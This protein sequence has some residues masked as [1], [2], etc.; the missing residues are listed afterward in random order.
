MSKDISELVKRYKE[1]HRSNKNIYFDAYEFEELADYFDS[2]NDIDEVKQVIE[3]GLKIHPKNSSLIIKKLKLIVYNY[4]YEKALKI[5]DESALEYDYDLNLLKIECYLVLGMEDEALFST[6]EILENEDGNLDEVFEDI[7]FVYFELSK[8]DEA[9]VFFKHSLEFNSE[10]LEVLNNLAYIYRQ[11]DSTNELIEI[12]N[13][14][15]DIDSYTYDSWVE[16]GK[17]YFSRQEYTKA[18]DALDFALTIKDDDVNVLKLKAECLP[19]LNRYEEAIQIYQK[20]VI[21][22]SYNPSVF[23][24]LIDLYISCEMYEKAHEVI[25][26]YEAS[27]GKSDD[28]I[29]KR[30]DIYIR[31][32]SIEKALEFVSSTENT[33]SK[34]FEMNMLM[35]EIYF[36]KKELK[37]AEYYF[38]IAISMSDK[39]SPLVYERLSTINII[40]KNYR[41]GLFYASRLLEAFPYV[42]AN[43]G[44]VALLYYQLELFE[45][46][47]ALIQYFTSS[48]FTSLSLFAFPSDTEP[49]TDKDGLLARFKV[50]R[51]KGTL[52]NILKHLD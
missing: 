17:L 27:F 25:D 26:S 24:P 44:R 31:A 43:I 8:L 32:G 11:K 38:A 51:S 50:A 29:S 30:A 22:E 4:D 15:L 47:E 2:L 12:H 45:K 48:D 41:L 7:G 40:H 18:I 37:C 52:L 28:S 13:K 21:E 9:L 42:T 23:L 14:I 20:L 3:D 6:E 36:R 34:S 39:I 46:L 1:A 49:F 16:L 35:G 10:N 33:C 19:L 5:I